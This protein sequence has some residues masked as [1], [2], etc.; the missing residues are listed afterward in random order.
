MKW[1]FKMGIQ[2]KIYIYRIHENLLVHLT[3]LS[4]II[5]LMDISILTNC[6]NFK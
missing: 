2:K 1:K 3:K 6:K 5:I 4:W